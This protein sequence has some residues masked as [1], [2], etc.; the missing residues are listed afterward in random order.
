MCRT[1]SC[2]LFTRRLD[3][4]VPV[5]V[6]APGG[7][8]PCSCGIMRIVMH[9]TC[10]R[11]ED[12]RAY[13]FSR[14]RRVPCAHTIEDNYLAGRGLAVPMGILPSGSSLSDANIQSMVPIEHARFS[15]FTQNMMIELL[16][17]V[18]I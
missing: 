14:R 13:S 15:K 11:R 2:H 17:R 10:S 16:C 4:P 12:T 8:T 7:V 3:A 6:E 5:H 9:L 1:A 18:H